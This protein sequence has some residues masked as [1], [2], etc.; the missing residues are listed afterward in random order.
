MARIGQMCRDFGQSPSDYLFNDL[1]CAHTRLLIDLEVHQ[2]LMEAEEELHE[3]AKA[4]AK[5]EAKSR[6]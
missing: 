4:K 1:T 6:R 3:K 2:M 5:R